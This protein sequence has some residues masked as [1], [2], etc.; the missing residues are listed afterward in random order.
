MAVIT[1]DSLKYVKKLTAA[2]VPSKQAEAQAIAFREAHE[3]N[4]DQLATKSDLEALGQN[5]RFEIVQ[6]NAELKTDII[7][8]LLSIVFSLSA[9]QTAV[10]ISSIKFI[11]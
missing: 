11:H 1:F 5:L 7:K 3:E 2:G 4:L 8:W 10:I 9:V 6:K